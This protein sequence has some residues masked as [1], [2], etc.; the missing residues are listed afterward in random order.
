LQEGEAIEFKAM[1]MPSLSCNSTLLPFTFTK[2]SLLLCELA[3]LFVLAGRLMP[4]SLW[5]VRR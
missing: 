4:M 2:K 1:P 5:C 3:A